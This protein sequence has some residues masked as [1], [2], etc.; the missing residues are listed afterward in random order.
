MLRILGT[1]HIENKDEAVNDS[2]DSISA[3]SESPSTISLFVGSAPVKHATSNNVRNEPIGN[4]LQQ[5]KYQSTIIQQRRSNFCRSQKCYRTPWT[6]MNILNAFSIDCRFHLDGTVPKE[7]LTK[8]FQ[9]TWNLQNAPSSK[10]WTT[11]IQDVRNNPP[12]HLL[13]SVPF[14]FINASRNV[15]SLLSILDNNIETF[16]K[17]R[18]KLHSLS[19]FK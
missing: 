8:H 9:L 11:V 7:Q 1:L 18:S 5:I 6:L 19:S 12:G 10:K 14:V 17:I 15:N 2:N 16:M 3:S 4:Q 13:L